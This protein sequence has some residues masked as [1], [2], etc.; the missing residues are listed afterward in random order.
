MPKQNLDWWDKWHWL[1]PD[2]I[3]VLGQRWLS[4]SNIVG[5]TL[6]MKFC[7][8][9]LG[10]PNKLGLRWPNDF[11]QQCLQFANK[12]PTIFWGKIWWANVGPILSANKVYNLPT[13]YQQI[14][15]ENYGGPTMAH[16]WPNNEPMVLNNR[17]TSMWFN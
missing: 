10:W 5:P 16:P 8:S 9:A 6:A 13:R 1:F 2:S 7:P 14:L 17:L 15:V 11:C 4:V 3:H 12:V